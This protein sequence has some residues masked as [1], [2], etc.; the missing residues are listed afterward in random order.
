[1]DSKRQLARDAIVAS[2]GRKVYEKLL[3]SLAGYSTDSH[4][5]LRYWHEVIFRNL[6]ESTGVSVDSF[7]E[8]AD[9]LLV[10]HVH[11]MPVSWAEGRKAS[12]Q[13]PIHT[14]EYLAAE[15][16]LFPHSQEVEWIEGPVAGAR[17]VRVLSCPK[18]VAA[19]RQWSGQL[20]NNSSKP[21]PLRGAA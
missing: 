11:G 7:A 4:P 6:S 19:R 1:M 9:L 18:C 15:A 21:T 16:E 17:T 12:G 3:R 14:S 10:C 5:R 8:A 13:P 20:P 2:E